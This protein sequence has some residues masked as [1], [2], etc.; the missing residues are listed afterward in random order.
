MTNATPAIEVHGAW[1]GAIGDPKR[2]FRGKVTH[3]KPPAF[4][5]GHDVQVTYHTEEQ[6]LPD[7]AEHGTYALSGRG[8]TVK[9][10]SFICR[11]EATTGKHGTDDT[12]PANWQAVTIPD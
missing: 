2:H 10:V 9:L 8:K 7:A 5:E 11:S 4:A 1:Q 12:Q 3:S 6:R